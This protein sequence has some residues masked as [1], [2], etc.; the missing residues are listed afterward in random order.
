MLLSPV[1]LDSSLVASLLAQRWVVK[2]KKQL[3][4]HML[5]GPYHKFFHLFYLGSSVRIILTNIFEANW[6]LKKKL[7]WNKHLF[8]PVLI[9][10]RVSCQEALLCDLTPSFQQLTSL[11]WAWSWR[12]CRKTPGSPHLWRLVSVLLF[13]VKTRENLTAL[14]MLVRA[15]LWFIISDSAV[16]YKTATTIISSFRLK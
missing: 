13:I 15:Q 4:L 6:V 16:L 7:N 5:S 12:R 1:P 8:S 2:K 3:Y 10:T 14:I 11:F 9:I